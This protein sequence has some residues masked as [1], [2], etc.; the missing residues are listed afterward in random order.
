MGML[1]LAALFGF[2][3]WTLYGALVVTPPAHVLGETA[4]I[5]YFHVPVAWVAVL[6]FTMSLWN[7]VVVLRRHSYEADMKAE[8]SARMGL[9][10][11]VLA[12]ISGAFFA[13]SAWNMYWN[14]DPRQVSITVLLL[15]YMAYFGLRSA[16]PDFD[17]RIRLAAVYAILAFAVMPFLV[18]VIPRVYMSLH[19]D[20]IINA[21]GQGK[22]LDDKMRLV[23][24]CAAA[25]Y[26][27]LY[28]KLYN[29]S[30]R[31]ERIARRKEG[32]DV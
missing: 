19:P 26:T 3:A 30:V 2:M 23:F 1:F 20:T 11:C 27:F 17:R 7:S 9:W 31:V 10:F 5:I 21:D 18:F 8:V 22:L 14:W 13:K 32:W 24:W 12:T 16:T 4:R 28:L 15:V 29:L 25:G 6:A